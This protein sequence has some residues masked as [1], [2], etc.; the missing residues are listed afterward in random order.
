M[1]RANEKLKNAKYVKI[2]CQQCQLIHK[3][4]KDN[5]FM[6]YFVYRFLPRFEPIRIRFIFVLL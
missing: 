6:N 2:F 4:I 3:T 5:L 1:K